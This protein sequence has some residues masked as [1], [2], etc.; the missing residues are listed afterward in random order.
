MM[1]PYASPRDNSNGGGGGGGGEGGGRAD[2]DTGLEGNALEQNSGPRCAL[3]GWN[4]GVAV[5]VLVFWGKAGV[6]ACFC[7]C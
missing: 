7:L 3:C 5:F 6:W 4:F 2:A 1:E